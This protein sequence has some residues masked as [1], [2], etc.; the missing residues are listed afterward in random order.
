[1]QILSKLPNISSLTLQNAELTMLHVGHL[2]PLG[3]SL[4]SLDLSYNTSI[5][6][7]CLPIT[8]FLP[9]LNQI[10]LDRTSITM[11]G[12]R[13]FAS[14]AL[15]LRRLP[16]TQLIVPQECREY[17]L[18]AK[19]S[20]F[21]AFSIEEP[22]LIIKVSLF[23][24]CYQNDGLMRCQSADAVPDLN[25][26]NVYENLRFHSRAT[27]KTLYTDDPNKNRVI[28]SDL[29]RERYAASHAVKPRLIGRQNGGS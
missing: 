1:M 9:F 18:Q 6:D 22:Y 13:T 2:L 25:D 21:Y 23:I 19:E 8:A 5:D 20:R 16:Y 3:A 28:L 14:V 10:N 29:L 11:K 4:Q 12:L 26:S 24:S 15:P 27:G 17:L 7:S